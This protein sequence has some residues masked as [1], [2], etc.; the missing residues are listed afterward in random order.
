MRLAVFALLLV[1]TLPAAAQSDIVSDEWPS[2]MV[3]AFTNFETGFSGTCNDLLVLS[4][5]DRQYCIDM[6]DPS[7][8]VEISST[9]SHSAT[10]R[11]KNAGSSSGGYMACSA[12]N[13]FDGA[14][15]E[16]VHD[17]YFTA[18]RVGTMYNSGS[19]GCIHS[20]TNAQNSIYRLDCVNAGRPAGGRCNEPAGD[21]K[22]ADRLWG[23]VSVDR[24]CVGQ[25]RGF[26]GANVNW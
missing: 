22:R 25:A 16:V 17:R 26:W 11:Y 9:A 13:S 20:M 12:G 18:K 3:I 7:G 23:D 10:P 19:Y 15:C 24:V 6:L 5:D 14:S 8:W 1:L 2:D 4:L 21:G